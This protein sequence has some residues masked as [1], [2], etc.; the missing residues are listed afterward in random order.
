VF[1]PF[2]SSLASTQDTI[3]VMRSGM[4]LYKK[5]ITDIDSISFENTSFNRQSVVNKIAKD[6]NFSIFYQGLVATGLVDSLMVD[7][8]KS[9]NWNQ[10]KSLIA[11]QGGSDVQRELPFLR[12]YGFTVLMESDSTMRANGITDLESMKAYADANVYNADPSIIDVTNRQNSL[13]RFIAYHIINKKLSISKF[14]DAYDTNN[15]IKTVD[16][17]EYIE[18]MCPN[19]LIEIKKERSSGLTNLINQSADAGSAIHIIKNYNDNNISNGYYYGIDK[20]MTYNSSIIENLSGKRL[21]FDMASLFPELTNNNMRAS[22]KVQAWVFPNGYIKDLTCSQA[23]KV[24]YYNANGDYC[25]Y[26]G[27]DVFFAGVYDFTFTTLS[28][29]AGAYE[30]R[31][32]YG[33]NNGSGIAEVYFDDIPAGVP[34][35]FRMSA[36]DPKI[37]YVTPGSQADDPYGYENDKALRNHGYMKGPASYTSRMTANA[38]G[39]VNVSRKVLGTYMF[40]NAGNHRI[41]IKGLMDGTLMIDYI[42]FVPVSALESEDIN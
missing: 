34:I 9:Y 30:V 41:T 12:R 27:D 38:R 25:D 39:N 20:I 21:R 36:T 40:M 8:D 32:G 3:Y 18:S 22:G 29:P 7:R 13:N 6:P 17:Y 31:I 37:G 24:Y 19:S 35:D 23:T 2:V 4:V 10:Y 42:E 33:P 14:I 16:M 5:A 1:L 15:M 11:N 26:Q 28:V